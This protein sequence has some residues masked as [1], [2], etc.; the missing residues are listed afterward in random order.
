M[1]AEIQYCQIYGFTGHLHQPAQHRMHQCKQIAAL[2][3]AA[4]NHKGVR[5]NRSEA[6]IA[7]LTDKALLLHGGQ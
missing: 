3:E 4:A 6:E 2:Q 1:I 5:A 7:N